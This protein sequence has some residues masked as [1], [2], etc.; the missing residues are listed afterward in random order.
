MTKK[1]NEYDIVGNMLI[2]NSTSYWI[3]NIAKERWIELNNNYNKPDETKDQ[4]DF[5]IGTF[6]EYAVSS[7]D[8]IFVYLKS[9][10]PKENGFVAMGQTIGK[11]LYNKD[12]KVQLYGDANL[13]KYCI[14]FETIVMF[15]TI[16][17]CKTIE[18]N[19]LALPGIKSLTA[20]KNKYTT[21][22]GTLVKL[23]YALGQPLTELLAESAENNKN[24]EREQESENIELVDPIDD[25]IIENNEDNNSSDENI[26]PVD[27]EHKL[28]HIPI[29]IV[30][31]KAFNVPV[32]DCD[33][34]DIDEFGNTI[35]GN[36][37]C[38]YFKNHITMCKKCDITNNG[39]DNLIKSMDDCIMSYASGSESVADCSVAIE[40]YYS[41]KKYNLFG[42]ILDKTSIKLYHIIDKTS[43]YNNCI[44]V[45]WASPGNGEDVGN[46]ENNKDSETTDTDS[47]DD[48]YSD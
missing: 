27:E 26:E 3:H 30:L 44:L 35:D 29:M 38:E 13:Q 21:N 18:N 42:D 46:S 31:C 1:K 40:Y 14:T 36:A 43:I 32:V 16:L 12:N 48:D 9:K 45:L 19:I 11:V 5:K 37:K 7:M 34:N 33:E 28:G 2:N 8:V 17:T 4:D 47:E 6:D 22:A 20:F 10:S 24:V 23:P 25:A 15:E 41:S 39:T